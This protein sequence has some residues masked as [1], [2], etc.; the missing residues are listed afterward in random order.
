[1]DKTKLNKAKVYFNENG[2]RVPRKVLVL[3]ENPKTIWVVLVDNKIVKRNKKR[4]LI[5]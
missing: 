4:D 5:N 1:M 3:K 2:K